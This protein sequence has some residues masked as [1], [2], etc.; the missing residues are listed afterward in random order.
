MRLAGA[1]FPL[2]QLAYE[3]AVNFLL[4]QLVEAMSVQLRI[5]KAS[6]FVLL[7]SSCH[8]ILSS[9]VLIVGA[10]DV[11]RGHGQIAT[12]LCG[13]GIWSKVAVLNAEGVD[14]AA[15]HLPAIP[16]VIEA[17]HSHG[18]F[19]GTTDEKALRANPPGQFRDDQVE[20]ILPHS[21][22]LLV[23]ITELVWIFQHAFC[24]GA[25]GVGTFRSR[26]VYQVI[27]PVIHFITCLLQRLQ[28]LVPLLPHG[29]VLGI[30]KSVWGN[31]QQAHPGDHPTDS[32]VVPAASAG[33][34]RINNTAPQKGE[35]ER[36][37]HIQAI[38]LPHHGTLPSS[39]HTEQDIFPLGIT[40][41]VVQVCFLLRCQFL[42]LAAALPRQ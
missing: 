20:L 28:V 10:D 12:E 30:G 37:Q 21:V 13:V 7:D 27:R 34:M 24:F 9:K 25:V 22:A 3:G 41:Q 15:Q 16:L 14:E 33:A 4:H 32:E 8:A 31:H 39:S 1:V 42:S 35:P 11:Q 26:C 29:G 2:F 17:R 5:P 23:E 38:A 40:Q 18:T 6:D 19:R 36:V